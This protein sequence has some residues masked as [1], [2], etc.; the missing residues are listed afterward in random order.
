LLTELLFAALIIIV[1]MEATMSALRLLA[2]IALTGL[3]LAIILTLIAA[4]VANP[5]EEA[6][7]M[8]IALLLMLPSLFAAALGL[9]LAIARFAAVQLFATLLLLLLLVLVLCITRTVIIAARL[10]AT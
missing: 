1:A 9:T 8:F 2:P 3:M 4:L 10:S 5:S 7:V 6:L